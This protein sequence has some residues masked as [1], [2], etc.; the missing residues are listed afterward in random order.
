M[1]KELHESRKQPEEVVRSKPCVGSESLQGILDAI[2]TLGTH[3]KCS[4]NTLTDPFPS[5]ELWNQ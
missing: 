4:K 2:G 5:L 3:L 1:K